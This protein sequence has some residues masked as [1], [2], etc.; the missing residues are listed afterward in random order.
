[1][2]LSAEMNWPA[3]VVES[4]RFEQLPK[5]RSVDDYH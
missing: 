3:G 4:L 5:R 2:T 1:M